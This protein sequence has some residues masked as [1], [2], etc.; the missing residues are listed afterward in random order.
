M[1]QVV[2]E[3]LKCGDVVQGKS[4]VHTV[5]T[6]EVRNGVVFLCTRIGGNTTA[7][8]KVRKGTHVRVLKCSK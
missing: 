2:I 5:V 6:S 1:T 3:A 4:A 8:A 7:L